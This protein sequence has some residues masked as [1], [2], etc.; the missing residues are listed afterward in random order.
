MIIIYSMQIITRKIM[1]DMRSRRK[2]F[3]LPMRNMG[4]SAAE[5]LTATTGYVLED[6]KHPYECIHG[7]CNIKVSIIPM[8]DLKRKTI[9]KNFTM[10]LTTTI[11]ETMD[12]RARR[13]RRIR[14][15]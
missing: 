15:A 12:Y 4:E 1:R 3:L 5:A 11:I 6:D 8:Y 13:I 10:K 9:G 2:T 14:R 7:T